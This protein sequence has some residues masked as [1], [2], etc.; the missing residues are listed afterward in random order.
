MRNLFETNQSFSNWLRDTITRSPAT[1]SL[2]AINVIV[3]AL[4]MLTGGSESSINLYR[5]GAKFGPAVQDGDWHR[6]VVPMFLHAGFMHLGANTFALVIF[7][8]RLEFEFGTKAFLATYL[9]AGVCGVAASYLVSPVLSVGAS[10]AIFGI[11]GAFA[12]FAIKNRREIGVAANSLILNIGIIIGINVLSGLFIPVIDQGAHL[13]GLIAG[14]AMAW[15]VGPRR[16][17]QVADTLSA[18]GAP[19]VRSR[20][21][22][23]P[24]SRIATAFVIGIVVAAAIAMLVSRLVDYDVSVMSLYRTYELLT[25]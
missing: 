8:P 5:W 24:D 17:L 16:Q 3:F 23:A 7:G 13:G 1:S 4:L 18:F 2:V 15:F 22:R 11:I 21:V 10:G 9:V 20:F 19:V 14:A 25:R 12:V 6:L